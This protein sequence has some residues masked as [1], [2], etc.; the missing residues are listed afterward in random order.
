MTYQKHTITIY[1]PADTPELELPDLARE[2][3]EGSAYCS[4][5][6]IVTVQSSELPAGAASFFEEL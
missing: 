5:Q 3:H 4:E 2:A 6:V 1:A